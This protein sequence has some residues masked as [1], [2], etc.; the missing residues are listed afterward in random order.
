MLEQLTYKLKHFICGQWLDIF[1]S[2][3]G[4]NTF[5]LL[6]GAKARGFLFKPLRGKILL[7]IA[8]VTVQS[9][10]V[11]SVVHR[12]HADS[13]FCTAWLRFLGRISSEGRVVELG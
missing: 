7:L 1:L 9:F 8:E 4:R 6:E 12:E 13:L 5:R 10:V 2:F 3:A 11:S